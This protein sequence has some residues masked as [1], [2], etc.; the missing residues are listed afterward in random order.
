[1]AGTLWGDSP[2]EQSKKYLRQ[3]LWQLQATLDQQTHPISIHL[4]LL[5]PEWIQFNP[6]IDLWLD[7]SV[8][9][10]IF[11]HVQGTSVQN[12]DSHTRQSLQEAVQLYRGDL[13]EGCY[14][15]WCLYERER[16]QNMYFAMLDKLMGYCEIHGDYESGVNYGLIILRHDCARERTHQ[17]LMRLNYLAGDRATAL[18]QYERC[19]AALSEE[20]GV[21]PSRGTTILYEQIKADRLEMP[22]KRSPSVQEPATLHQVLSHL[23]QVQT[24]LIDL[25]Q[26][27]VQDIQ[28]IEQALDTHK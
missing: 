5:E 19:V 8:F 11:A 4:L 14:H 28:K 18:R 25:H 26:E 1:M 21:R 20:L 10:D 3:A 23:K 24:T 6:E 15:D 16:Y 12:I 2:A 13:L 27:V 17:Q 7:V 22:A 9:E